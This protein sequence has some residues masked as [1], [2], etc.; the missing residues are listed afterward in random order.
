MRTYG[1]LVNELTV[2]GEFIMRNNAIIPP[3][4]LRKTIIQAAHIGHFGISKTIENVKKFY[5]WPCM[6]SHVRKIINN[7][8]QCLVSDKHWKLYESPLHPVQLPEA[9]WSKVALDFSGPFAILKESMK[10]LIVL[11]D[12][13]SKWVYYAFVDSPSSLTAS[14]F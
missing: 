7:C 2:E 6:D 4:S 8:P 13:Y 3:C 1:L 12:Y 11:I 10:Y 9:P 14:I 5:W